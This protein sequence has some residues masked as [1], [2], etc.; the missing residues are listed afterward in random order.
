MISYKKIL[1][2]AWAITK[3]NKFL[4]WYGLLLFFGMSVNFWYSFPADQAPDNFQAPKV[5]AIEGFLN[6][7]WSVVVLLALACLWL[8]IYFRA[9]A[10]MILAI[11]MIAEKQP[12]SFLTTFALARSFITRLL[13]V[14]LFLQLLLGTL[15]LLIMI[16]VFYLFS[17]GATGRGIILGLLGALVFVPSAFLVS[18]A[19]VLTPMFLVVFNLPVF[20]GVRAAVSV[21]SEAWRQ[22]LWFSVI[23]AV[24]GILASILAVIASLPFVILAVLSYHRGGQIFGPILLGAGGLAIFLS[25]QA[26]ISAFQ[27]T[28]WVLFFMELVRPEKV[29]EEAVSVP[30]SAT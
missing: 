7:P 5:A 12:V 28:A 8:V 27:Q 20:Q 19:N 26:V 24:V 25:F 15:S 22:L 10:G 17:T 21:I 23:L 2:Q 13:G 29:E 30:D 1:K 11:K 9:K 3:T 4:W 16:P 6:Q 14:S 18:F